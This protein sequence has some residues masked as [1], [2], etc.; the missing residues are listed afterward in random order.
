MLTFL[1]TAV[2][3]S[4]AEIVTFSQDDIA[5]II[6]EVVGHQPPTGS[7]VIRRNASGT[8]LNSCYPKTV[9]VILRNNRQEQQPI[10][11]TVLSVYRLEDGSP[12]AQ[13][14][15]DE[16]FPTLIVGDNEHIR[17]KGGYDV[18]YSGRA[19]MISQKENTTLATLD[20]PYFTKINI[21]NFDGKRIFSRKGDLLL[22]GNNNA[23]GLMEA[24]IISSRGNVFTEAG[25]LN[26]RNV[27]AGIRVLDYSQEADELLLGGVDASGAASFAAYN[28]GSGHG[29][30]IKPQEPGD[31]EALYMPNGRL[32]NRLLGRAGA[33]PT[34]GSF[35]G[36]LFRGFRF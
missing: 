26:L 18:E 22:I 33:S 32:M 16:G 31:T 14:V 17:A 9:E 36:E 24:R 25:K 15:E 2:N 5:R 3:L 23:T 12:A 28:L 34:K 4:A 29:R 11:N 13:I 27:A 21:P 7:L 19:L 30:V 6:G 8:M 1:F 35:F 20:K 10:S